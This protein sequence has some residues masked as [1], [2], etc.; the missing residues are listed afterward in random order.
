MG[1]SLQ[2]ESMSDGNELTKSERFNILCNRGR[3]RALSYSL[4]AV[5]DID[6]K[7]IEIGS[8]T[9]SKYGA[10]T[11]IVHYLYDLREGV[12]DLVHVQQVITALADDVEQAMQEH[13]GLDESFGVC[14]Q[15]KYARN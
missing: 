3:T 12:D 9:L 8:T 2:S 5:L 4:S 1:M 13:F 15:A 6:P 14:F 11:H 10:R 7:R